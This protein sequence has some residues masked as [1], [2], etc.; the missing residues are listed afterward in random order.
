MKVF[1]QDTRLNYCQIIIFHNFKFLKTVLLLRHKLRCSQECE[2][3]QRQHQLPP[4]QFPLG[5]CSWRGGCWTWTSSP[6][7]SCSPRGPGPGTYMSSVS[8]KVLP[9]TNFYPSLQLVPGDLVV[10]PGVH[11]VA[12][13]LGHALDHLDDVVSEILIS[14]LHFLNSF[15]IILAPT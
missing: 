8:P 12:G 2:E 5:W 7:P 9:A 10:D 6:W 4:A 15:S 1:S 11:D 13:P 14:K 3:S